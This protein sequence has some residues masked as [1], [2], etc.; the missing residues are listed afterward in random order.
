MS[1]PLKQLE[2]SLKNTRE[3]YSRYLK[4]KRVALV[5]PAP[6]I[7]NS[8]QGVNLERYD[9]I[10]R[11]NKGVPPPPELTT[12]IGW[13]TD[14]LYN[15][16]NPSEECGGAIDIKL[17]HDN[18]IRFLVSPYAPYKS[19]R[20]A[21][22]I[23]VFGMRNLKDSNSV[24]FCHI[25]KNYFARLMSLIKLPNT[26][27]SAMLD[28]LQH[29]IKELY[30]TGFTFFKGGYVK[31]YRGYSEAQVLA[32][33]AKYNLHDQDRQLHYMQRILHDNPRVKMDQALSE[34]ISSKTK[35][36][37]K[38]DP[39]MIRSFR[40]ETSKTVSK[41]ASTK[42]I[43]SKV[44]ITQKPKATHKKVTVVRAAV[45]PTKATKVKLTPVTSKGRKAIGKPRTM[46]GRKR[47]LK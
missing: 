12:D 30:I 13:R 22:D 28:L 33:M 32:R 43:Q 24:P 46:S 15:C 27:I 40:N 16:M 26:G 14:V 44:T 8:K 36:N 37:F 34:I 9:V 11:L 17:L 3:E 39:E 25:D 2:K 41:P 6:S 7:L 21:R 18:G 31:Q 20:F 19:Y 42:P 29:D 23:N 1:N 5:G 35:V 10:V 45:I 38:V 4:G 47:T